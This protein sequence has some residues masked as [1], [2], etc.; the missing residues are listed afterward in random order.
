MHSCLKSKAK[1][2]IYYCWKKYCQNLATTAEMKFPRRVKEAPLFCGSF[3]HPEFRPRGK[4]TL[5]PLP[6]TIAA[7]VYRP[8]S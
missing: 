8:Q 6:P 1:S 3:S 4:R 5:Y 7:Q 2:K